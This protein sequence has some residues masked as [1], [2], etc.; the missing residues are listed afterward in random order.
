M[1]ILDLPKPN[2]E[3][4]QLTLCTWTLC[5]PKKQK[6]KTNTNIQ[7]TP[8]PPP[9][10]PTSP[11]PRAN[12]RRSSPR[13]SAGGRELR[14][15]RPTPRTPRARSAA[16]RAGRARGVLCLGAQGTPQ[17]FFAGSQ[18][19]NEKWRE[20]HKPSNWWFPLGESPFGSFPNS[21]GRSGLSS[22]KGLAFFG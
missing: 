14:N 16:R 20:A 1:W 18:Q 21:E 9:A 4:T 10:E 3:I 17:E 6:K 2:L 7:K 8:P 15:S 13:G 11:R 19:G 22:S 5:P 12:G